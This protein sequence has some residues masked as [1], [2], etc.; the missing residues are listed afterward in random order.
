MDF[1][2]HQQ[3]NIEP[4]F[5]TA[6]EIL[7]CKC[8]IC[9]RRIIWCITCYKH[10]S[11]S[12]LLK[13]TLPESDFRSWERDQKGRNILRYKS[14]ICNVK[15]E[16]CIYNIHTINTRRGSGL[17]GG[18]IICDLTVPVSRIIFHLILNGLG[19]LPPKLDNKFPISHLLQ[20]TCTFVPS[21]ILPPL[22]FSTDC[23]YRK[24]NVKYW[25]N[26]EELLP[27]YHSAIIIP[28]PTQKGHSGRRYFLSLYCDG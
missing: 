9:E 19:I 12:S 17:E 5:N 11:T 25:M 22:N 7:S 2:Y 16:G 23:S 14:W 27:I 20:P 10:A 26:N 3:T 18:W 24:L 4:N 8:T 28:S 21:P 6:A 1:G 13:S 15:N